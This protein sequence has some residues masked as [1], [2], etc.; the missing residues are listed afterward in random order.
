MIIQALPFQL[1]VLPQS[2]ARPMAGTIA[3]GP[4]LKGTIIMDYVLVDS[5][6][7]VRYHLVDDDDELVNDA[8]VSGVLYDDTNEAI[9]D[10]LVF[11]SL[12]DGD[13]QAVI[14]A[15]IGLKPNTY[16]TIVITAEVDGWQ[17]KDIQSC[18]VLESDE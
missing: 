12:G 9:G 14:P 17:T 3:V 8:T 10:E 7:L 11:E 4:R 2:S 18:Q 16:A 6:N 5:N 13:Y 15:G 1:G